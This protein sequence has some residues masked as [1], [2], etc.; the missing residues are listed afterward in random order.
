MKNLE[1]AI[2]QAK[3][4][5]EIKEDA[6]EFEQARK[7]RYAI[8]MAEDALRSGNVTRKVEMKRYLEQWL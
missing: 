8:G 5:A 7:M 4:L 6:H 2:E 1:E 3:Q